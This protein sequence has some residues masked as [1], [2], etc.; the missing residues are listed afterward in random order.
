[1][2]SLEKSVEREVAELFEKRFGNISL[3]AVIMFT[4][5]IAILWTGVETTAQVQTYYQDYRELQELKKELR[6]LEI[7][8]QRLLI[9]QQTFSAT[10]QIA[11]RAVSE[12]RMFS[13]RVKDTLVLQPQ[14]LDAT[15][16]Y[17]NNPALAASTIAV[18][19]EVKQNTA[20]N[21]LTDKLKNTLKHNVD[22][23]DGQTVETETEHLETEH[24]VETA[25]P[26]DNININ[27]EQANTQPSVT[28]QQS[29]RSVAV[30]E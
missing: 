20:A 30:E 21:T 14:E 27:N 26:E 29:D 7:E 5:A 18:E 23:I 22:D 6:I 4:L 2:D 12:L 16:L 19:T 13:P 25:K 1:M 17:L 8:H 24:L 11:A 9:E 15:E 10:P 3:Y 28:S